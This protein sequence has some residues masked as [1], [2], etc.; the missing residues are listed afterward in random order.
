MFPKSGYSRAQ[1]SFPI[2]FTYVDLDFV[3]EIVQLVGARFREPNTQD[4][5]SIATR[6]SQTPN[7]LPGKCHW[8]HY[9]SIGGFP[10]IHFEGAMF[11]IEHFLHTT[12]WLVRDI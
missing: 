12:R 8:R 4:R 5:F 9:E 1:S 11:V 7:V 10:I 3:E 2:V 6:G